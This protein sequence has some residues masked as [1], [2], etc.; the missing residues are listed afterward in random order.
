[1][2]SPASS[3]ASDSTK[4]GGEDYTTKDELD[5]LLGKH[6]PPKDFSVMF[7]ERM[8][9]SANQLFKRLLDN[10]D[11]PIEEMYKKRGE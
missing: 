1:L 3:F 8:Q 10:G 2:P 11:T 9:A 7:E 4:S 5:K 6:T